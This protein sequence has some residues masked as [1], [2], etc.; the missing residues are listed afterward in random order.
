MW[1]LVLKQY[2]TL[3]C[4][5]PVRGRV[6]WTNH[7]GV[8]CVWFRSRNHHGNELICHAR[9]YWVLELSYSRQSPGHCFRTSHSCSCSH[10][11]LV[12]SISIWAEGRDNGEVHTWILKLTWVACLF[13]IYTFEW[14]FLSPVTN[15]TYSIHTHDTCSSSKLIYFLTCTQCDSFY[16]GET[17]NSLSTR[18]N[19]H[20]SSSNSPDNLALP[21]AIHIRSF[22]FQ[23]EF[24]CTP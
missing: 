8:C 10:Y 5:S 1:Q 21:V 11:G 6:S 16:V 9:C 20:W 15:L 22:W 23:L 3:L 24:T 12:C 18:M 17:K 19:G 2:F 4:C 13:L 14:N 7:T